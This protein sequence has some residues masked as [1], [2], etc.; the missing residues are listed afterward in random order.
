MTTPDFGAS[1]SLNALYDAVPET[2]LAAYRGR[3]IVI[4]APSY[5]FLTK[6]GEIDHARREAALGNLEALGAVPTLMAGAL[7][8]DGRYAGPDE[9][10]AADFQAALTRD[11]AEAD[12]VMPIRGGY[13][14]TR[15]LP[16]LD[17]EVIGRAAVP[18]VGFSDF[19]AFNLALLAKTGRASWHGPM[20]G[21]F[22][23]PDPYMVERFA[24][25]FGAELD[26]I[27]WEADPHLLGKWADQTEQRATGLLWGGNLCLIESL[28]G[29]AW[30]PPKEMLEGGI[31]FLEDVGEYAYRVERMLLTLLDA[32]ILARQRAVL[33]GAFTN[34]DD[35][36]RFSGDHCLADSLAYIR[37]RLPASIPV[38]TGDRKSVV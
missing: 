21:S 24:V 38:V 1:H 35:S 7:T 11:P 19:T 25:V 3:R 17:W 28:V 37:R 12:L 32:G 16:L 18:M 33:L 9:V 20:L 2:S 26:P 13:G 30:M 22:D 36:I 15:L 34:A 5:Q 31:L 8:Q 6:T 27:E 29:T 23:N 10:R 14:M 4:P